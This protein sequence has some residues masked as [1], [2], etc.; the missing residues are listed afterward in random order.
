MN[1]RLKTKCREKIEKEREK[2]HRKTHFDCNS[3][4]VHQFSK[5][6]TTI[7]LLSRAQDTHLSVDRC[8]SLRFS[9]YLFGVRFS[10]A[11]IV[12]VH[13]PFVFSGPQPKSVVCLSVITFLHSFVSLLFTTSF[14]YA[15]A[16]ILF[17]LFLLKF[18]FCIRVVFFFIH[19]VSFFPFVFFFRCGFVRLMAWKLLQHLQQESM[20]C[21]WKDYAK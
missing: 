5:T 17:V 15:L 9:T 20:H 11:H 2:K 21:D 4:C 6:Q 18:K 12:C 14:V 1:S 19:F 7:S 8:I 16:V 3:K 10:L 13:H